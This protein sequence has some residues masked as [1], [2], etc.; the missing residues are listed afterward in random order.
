MKKKIF[1][2]KF[3]IPGLIIVALTILGFTVYLKINFKRQEVAGK[4]HLNGKFANLVAESTPTLII[5]GTPTP[6]PTLT[7]QQVFEAMNRKYGPCKSVPILMYH[8]IMDAKSAKEIKAT[9]L[10]VTPDVFRQ[11]LDYLLGNGY[12]FIGL[13]EMAERIRN[14]SLPNKPVVLTFDDGYNDFYDNVYPIL[15]EKGI[16]ATVFVISQFVGGGQYFNWNEVKEMADSGLVLV[17]NHTLNH[18]SL[19]KLSRDEEI[20]QIVSAKAVIQ[21]HI[22]KTTNY[23]AYPYGSSNQNA[24]DILRDNGFVGAVTTVIGRTQCLGLPYD[25]QRIRIGGGS[26]SRYGL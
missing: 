22:G 21:D 11:Q 26:L 23:F 15:K 16:K 18:S 19:P 20:N 24:K 14:N 3:T 5:T 13:D 12:S 9:Y 2:N 17:G 25:W 1:T 6:T 8:H 7:P 10:N 4:G